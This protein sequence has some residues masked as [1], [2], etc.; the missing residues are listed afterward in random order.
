MIFI[1]KVAVLKF[2]TPCLG[3][4]LRYFYLLKEKKKKIR[5]H[6]APCLVDDGSSFLVLLV[7]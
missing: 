2:S 4:R 5:D 3:K 1:E 7:S 6:L